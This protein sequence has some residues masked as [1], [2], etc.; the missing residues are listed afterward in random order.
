MLLHSFSLFGDSFN[1]LLLIL[2]N[3]RS[4]NI[5]ELHAGELKGVSCRNGTLA[6]DSFLYRSWF[7]RRCS[8]VVS[9]L[10]IIRKIIPGVRFC[11]G[12][13]VAKFCKSSASLFSVTFMHTQIDPRFF[14]K[15]LFNLVKALTVWVMRGLTLQGHRLRHSLCCLSIL[16]CV[17]WCSLA[18][19]G[20]ILRFES[21]LDDRQHVIDALQGHQ[22]DTLRVL[23]YD[24]SSVASLVGV[25]SN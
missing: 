11:F 10:L 13:G 19:D 4:Q 9:H 7:F 5:K 12:W 25:E 17:V 15:L 21:C 22:C 1:N 14:V 8:S 24:S 6:R 3:F 16:R 2:A 20:A 18:F 23:I